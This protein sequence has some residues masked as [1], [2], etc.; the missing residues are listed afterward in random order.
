MVF[1]IFCFFK[2]FGFCNLLFY[3]FFEHFDDFGLR[4]QMG[5]KNGALKKKLEKK[6]G[7]KKL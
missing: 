3:L 6:S 7:K 4:K 5:T 1:V 2:C